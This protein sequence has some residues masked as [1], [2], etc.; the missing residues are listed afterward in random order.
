MPG[1]GM[2]TGFPPDLESEGAV[3]EEVSLLLGKR[4]A[5]AGYRSDTEEGGEGVLFLGGCG[6]DFECCWSDGRPKTPDRS[7]LVVVVM[8][9]C[10]SLVPALAFGVFI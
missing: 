9:C 7:G 5:K 8:G 4:G 2:G 3:V 6:V 1:E 10:S